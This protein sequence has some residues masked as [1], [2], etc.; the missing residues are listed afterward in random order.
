M[1][2][3]GGLAVEQPTRQALP[4]TSNDHDPPST[5]LLNDSPEDSNLSTAETHDQATRAFASNADSVTR[6]RWS[7]LWNSSAAVCVGHFLQGLFGV[8]SFRCAYLRNRGFDEENREGRM[9]VRYDPDRTQPGRQAGER[10]QQQA[11][12]A[13]SA[14]YWGQNIGFLLSGLTAA[15]GGLVGRCAQIDQLRQQRRMQNDGIYR[16]AR[17]RLIY[18]SMSRNNALS[19]QDWSED[20]QNMIHTIY[21][22][23]AERAADAWKESQDK[24]NSP[25]TK[26]TLKQE[27]NG[28]VDAFGD[29]QEVPRS[30]RQDRKYDQS[31]ITFRK[32]ARKWTKATTAAEKARLVNRI[33]RTIEGYAVRWHFTDIHNSV[34]TEMA[35]T[36]RQ[37]QYGRMH[38]YLKDRDVGMTLEDFTAR[39]DAIVDAVLTDPNVVT[40]EFDRERL[41]GELRNEV[42]QR[43]Q[44]Q[45]RHSLFK[46]MT[47]FN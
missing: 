31:A 14:E 38:R 1:S 40:H 18:K 7:R 43:W 10:T 36:G 4:A 39:Y 26:A 8:A 23:V 32:Q 30:F 42:I 33:A 16:A 37:W 11:K 28:I 35:E 17:G 46:I 6:S 9:L 29:L 45:P 2:L 44:S 15:L 22:E 21:V 41:R 20:R 27:I 13:D 34:A 3:N 5:N 47:S 25:V 12:I 19:L 24:T